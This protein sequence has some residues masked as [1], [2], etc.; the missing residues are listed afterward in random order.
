MASGV[1]RF[2]G[3]EKKAMR[4]HF[5]VTGLCVPEKHYMVDITERI[6]GIRKMVDAGDYFTINRARQ[7]GKTTTLAALAKSLEKIYLVFSLD[8]QALGSASFRDENAF[9]LA[10]L[11][12]FARELER[13]QIKETG[14][15]GRLCE[16]IR[17]TL[18]SKDEKF[19]LVDLFEYLLIFCDCFS[20]AVVLMID[21]VDSASNNQVFLDFLAQLRGYYLERESKGTRTFQSVILAGVYDVKNLKRKLR[22]D[23]DHKMNS[24]WNIA[25]DFDVDMSLSKSGIEKMLWEYER[26]CHTGMDPEE[27]ASMLYGYTS[28]YPYLVSKLCKLLDEKVAARNEADHS[29]TKNGFLTAVRLLLSENNTLFESLIGKLADFPEL[30]QMLAELLFSGKEISYNPT[31]PA[32]NLAIMFGFVKNREG[33]IIPANR[34]FDTLLYNHFLSRDEQQITEI[35]KASLQ[36]KSQFIQDGHLD[37]RRVLEKFVEHFHEL[38][39]ERKEEFVEEEG[40]RYFLLYLRPIINGSGNYYIESRTRSLGKTDLIV[41]YHGERFVIEM[42]IWRGKEYHSRGEKQ[43]VGYLD[44]YRLDTGYMLSF[45]FNRNKKIGI[46]ESRVGGKT[47]IEAVV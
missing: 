46:Q 14:Q 28:G 40:R 6:A 24:P 47:L 33:K 8:F 11:R 17:D 44:D 21:E 43:L 9:S 5:N 13:K 20:K 31:S 32:V 19:D 1:E 30:D 36:D 42:K 18:S 34:I 25:A 10:F 23:E 3:R 2:V 45:C 16:D 4:K 26:D 22:T 15:L 29:W 37:M 41:D 27:M 7:Y 35:Y 12:I 38:Y 39:G